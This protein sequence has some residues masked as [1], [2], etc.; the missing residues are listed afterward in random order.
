M[1]VAMESMEAFGLNADL[2]KHASPAAKPL[3]DRVDLLRRLCILRLDEE[4]RSISGPTEP[5]I[6]QDYEYDDHPYHDS[7]E[8]DEQI[9]TGNPVNGYDIIIDSLPPGAIADL[10]DIARRMTTAGFGH[11]CCE[12]YAGFCRSFFDES[13][14]ILAFSRLPLTDS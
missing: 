4:F 8:L 10:N 2:N 7:G 1:L 5:T 13:V 12:T 6:L 9:P 3:I 14:A 11:E